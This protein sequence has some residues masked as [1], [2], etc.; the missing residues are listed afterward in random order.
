MKITDIQTI[1]TRGIGKPWLFCI[2]RTDAGITGYSEFGFG[3]LP[4]GIQGLVEDFKRLL[5]GKD[6]LPVERRYA[7]LRS[8]TEYTAGGATQK[9]LA[10][11]EL[12]LWDIKGKEAGKPVHELLGGP[13][14]DGQ[15]VYWSHLITYQS[16]FAEEMGVKG[17]DSWDDIKRCTREAIDAGY[18]AVKTNF[19]FPG[20]NGAERSRR[21]S[22]PGLTASNSLLDHIEKQ[23]GL[24]RE[25]A[26]P[27]LD[28]ALD[29]NKN[30]S[31]E[32]QIEI[33]RVMEPFNLM[34]LEI[35]N[36]DPVS[37]RQVRDSTTTPILTGEALLGV[38]QVRPFLER[39]SMAVTKLDMQWQGMISARQVALMAGAFQQNVAPH[40]FNGHLSTFQ[41]LNLCASV[42]NA[43]IMETDPLSAVFRDE[44]FTNIPEVENGVTKIPVGPGWGTDLNEH[45]AEKLKLH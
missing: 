43:R 40:N 17:V 10:G 11:V 19:V 24:M 29:I 8:A 9:A 34:W 14:K 1:V 23:I 20:A 38:E 30:F 44:L 3:G 18:D 22:E 12:A 28:I 41:S 42:N 15:R 4:H 7:E 13:T 27:D 31:P 6:P 45:A 25:E 37:L 35:D 33:A 26:G 36:P 21:M 16:L 5:V 32:A 39:G 2:I